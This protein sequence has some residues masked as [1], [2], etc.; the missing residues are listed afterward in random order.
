MSYAEQEE[1]ARTTKIRVAVRGEG[2]MGRKGMNNLTSATYMRALASFVRQVAGGI[3][4]EKIVDRSG[5]ETWV[6]TFHQNRFQFDLSVQQKCGE[7]LS[8][9]TAPIHPLGFLLN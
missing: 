9:S 4:W 7:T 2:R 8:Q 1:G 5:S 6:R 3:E